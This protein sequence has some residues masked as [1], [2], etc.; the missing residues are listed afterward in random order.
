MDLTIVLTCEYI[1]SIS[2]CTS[3]LIA[4]DINPDK[5]DYAYKEYDISDK[6]IITTKSD[7]IIKHIL[8]KKRIR[9]NT[10]KYECVSVNNKQIR[11]IINATKHNLMRYPNLMFVK[12]HETFNNKIHA[13]PH[14]LAYLHFGTN[15]NQCVKLPSDLMYVQFG[16]KFDQVITTFPDTLR[17]IHFG[18]EFN[19]ALPKLPRGLICLSFGPS[20]DQHII[21][22]PNTLKVLQIKTELDNEIPKLPDNLECLTIYNSTKLP[23]KLKT[24][25]W[26]CRNSD[27]PI[28]FDELPI[29][30][31]YLEYDSDQEI[32]LTSF[33]SLTQ[34]K[35][36]IWN[37]SQ[38]LP[39]LPNSVI[40]LMLGSRYNH[41]IGKLSDAIRK[42]V[43]S[44]MY[45]RYN[46]VRM[47]NLRK[48]NKKKIVVHNWYHLL[49]AMQ[50]C[51]EFNM[52]ITYK[53]YT[54]VQ[55]VIMCLGDFISLIY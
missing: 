28:F 8:S 48:L 37:S 45:R 29:T 43:I 6:N 12:F 31:E 19:Q 38:K 10:A 52:N 42:I 32:A 25:V 50:N 23:N 21:S 20:F 40:C 39:I 34:L 22:L 27:E 15:F 4:C 36:L 11:K 13:F 1:F 18:R 44:D 35:C 55:I 2:E 30:L 16:E 26:R 5:Y 33:A 53:K 24:L 9:K 54:N 3:F 41:E 17:I 51:L 7:Y 47:N 14:T 46:I 49:L